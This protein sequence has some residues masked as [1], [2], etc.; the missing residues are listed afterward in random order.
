MVQAA[1]FD[2]I[3]MKS[4]FLKEDAP[5]C[6][7]PLWGQ[8]RYNAITKTAKAIL[9]GQFIYPPEFD[10]ATREICEECARIRCMIPKDTISTHVTKEDYQRQWK[11]RRESTS[12]S[13]SG[14]HFGH[15]IVGTQSDHISHFHT[16]KATLIMKLG[17]VLD[18][19]TRGLLEL[20]EKMFGYMLVTKL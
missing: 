1:T 17:I 15:Y 13:I 7:G 2:N 6:S 18:R 12:L 14:K 10:Q 9:A 11:G 20:V 3:Q 8:F 4:F 19:W 16:L 5:I